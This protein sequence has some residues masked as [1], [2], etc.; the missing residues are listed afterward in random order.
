[1]TIQKININS[2]WTAILSGKINVGGAWKSISSGKIHDNGTWKTIFTFPSS[3]EYEG[4]MTVGSWYNYWFG[5]LPGMSIGS[6]NPTPVSVGGLSLSYLRWSNNSLQLGN[7]PS[8]VTCE[9]NGTEYVVNGGSLSTSNP[10]PAAGQ[11]C[12]IKI[13]EN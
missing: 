8:S 6:M 7:A 12:T 3:W 9:I 10:F 13:K 4:T 2:T 1:M 5:W 11:T